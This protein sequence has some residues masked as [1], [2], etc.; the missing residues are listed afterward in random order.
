MQ[1]T[2]NSR[3]KLTPRRVEDEQPGD[4]PR[5]IWDTEVPELFLRIQPS[6]AK[7]FNVRVSRTSSHSLGKFP[8][9]T[10]KAARTQALAILGDLAKGETPA[11]IARRKEKRQRIAEGRP[12]TL[13]DLL[14]EYRVH[15]RHKNR[16]GD[17]IVDQIEHAF[18]DLLDWK[19]EKISK[20]AVEDIFVRRWNAGISQSSTNR[21]LAILKAALNW[22]EDRGDIKENPLVKL[23]P[24]RKASRS[25]VRYLSVDERDHLYTALVERDT[26]KREARARVLAGGRKQ[27]KGVKPIPEDG[28]CDQLEPFVRV[29]LNTGCR[30]GEL[31]ALTWSS[32]DFEARL[33]TVRDDTAKSGKT[34]HIPLNNEAY[35]ALERWKRQTG[36][37]GKVFREDPRKAWNG[38]LERAQ[39][40]NFRIHD[41]RHDFASRLVMAGASLQVVKELLGHADLTMAL[42]YA[43]LAPERLSASVAL[44]D[45]PPE[46]VVA[47]KARA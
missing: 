26:E 17:K 23:K 41:M 3:I 8:H 39:I 33:L 10:V 35:D 12:E 9:L 19:L 31:M 36:C 27:H 40:E 15:Q 14:V 25:V 44:L 32:I 4:K 11:P 5:R 7:S 2:P 21:D 1:S 13:R 18:A 29:A 22:A 38:L 45:E 34:R 16:T 6:G 43:H 37:T 20:R 47:L 46:N 24:V 30:K 28:Y 42:R